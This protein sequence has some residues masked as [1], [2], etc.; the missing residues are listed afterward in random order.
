MIE[1]LPLFQISCG[2]LRSHAY[3]NPL[4]DLCNRHASLSIRSYDQG[5]LDHRY[6]DLLLVW[7]HLSN[8]G[9]MDMVYQ[10]CPKSNVWEV[11]LF[12]L[13]ECGCYRRSWEVRVLWVVR[14]FRLNRRSWLNSGSW[15]RMVSRSL[16][17]LIVGRKNTFLGSIS[18]LTI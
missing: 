14:G 15:S 13:A 17:V 11:L 2:F 10:V 4:S 8:R 1:R 3:N 9:S 5:R 16:D 12:C 6:L 18:L 7:L